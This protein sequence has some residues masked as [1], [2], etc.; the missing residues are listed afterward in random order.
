VRPGTAEAC[1]LVGGLLAYAVVALGV[2]H[3]WVSGLGAI[4][5]A[6]LLWRRHRRAR[7]AA[8]VLLT[9]IVLRGVETGNWILA[10][11]AVVGLLVLQTRAALRAWPRLRFGWRRGPAASDDGDTMARP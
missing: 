1:A 10:A 6:V 4:A 2:Q 3:W 9:L 11:L 7:F 8:Y 5:T